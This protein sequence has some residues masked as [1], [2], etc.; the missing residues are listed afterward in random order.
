MKIQCLIP[1]AM[2]IRCV[3]LFW[4]EISTIK[5]ALVSRG[6]AQQPLKMLYRGKSCESRC[7]FDYILVDYACQRVHM[8][9]QRGIT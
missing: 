1:T 7:N 9:I 2:E 3:L 6:A 8:S 4:M 5:L